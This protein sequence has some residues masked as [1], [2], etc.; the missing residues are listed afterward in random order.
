MTTDFVTPARRVAVAVCLVWGLVV[1][2]LVVRT[3]IRAEDALAAQEGRSV[4]ASFGPDFQP[5]RLPVRT[6][7]AAGRVANVV[8]TM[9]RLI[10]PAANR[11]AES[12][13]TLSLGR[14]W[15]RY[16]SVPVKDA[17]EW[18]VVGAV[19][20]RAD[21]WRGVA[22]PLAVVL[23]TLLVAATLGRRGVVRASEDVSTPPYF[24]VADAI[25]TLTV[26]TTG[27]LVLASRRLTEAAAI[28]PPPSAQVRFDPLSL[29]LP[30]TRTLGV[31]LLGWCFAAACALFLCAWMASPRRSVAERR[32]SA[33]AWSFL[34]PSGVHLLVFTL[35]PLLFTAWL[36]LHRWDL[37]E[38]S[39]PFIGLTN[40]RELLSDPQ[41]W[42]ALRNTALYTLYVPVTMVLAL[43]AAMLLNQPLRGMRV[44]R[45][46]VFLPT[47][48]SYVAIA[49][50]WQWIYHADYGLLNY[51][52]RLVGGTGVDWLGNPATALVALMIVSA[53]V[54]LGY[55]M[56]VY[57]AGLQGIPETLLEAARLDG[58]NAWHRFTQVTWPLL[59]PV[60]LYLLVT[61][62]IWS[63]QVFALVY[64]MTEGGPARST[65]VLVFQIYQQAWE[66][67]RMGY[68]SALSWVLFAIL[69]G[70]TLLQWRLLNRKVEYAG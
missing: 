44:L 10:G 69:L 43:G 8:R 60:S 53:W 37:L 52:I 12:E 63:F 66:F 68:A 28:L 26:G 21:W 58:A 49:M 34:A 45:A 18:D 13:R 23:A 32:E 4:A 2:V 59:R 1:S 3:W 36:S 22:I 33:T 17:D 46:M 54:Q 64:V 70:L 25:A 31:L 7:V 27:A 65:D 24:L 57:L 67:R 19:V 5:T 16:V 48:V 20:L 38:T 41:F 6:P 40:Y 14:L 11:I 47:V 51:L 56:I 55:Q 35:G 15:S 50:V 9:E 39:R 29:P 62:I 30:G 61:G 42:N